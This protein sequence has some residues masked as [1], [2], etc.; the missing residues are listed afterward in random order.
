MLRSKNN[1][2]DILILKIIWLL[3]IGLLFKYI[4]KNKIRNGIVAFLYKQ[5]VTWLFGLLVVEKGLIKYPVRFFKKANKSSFSFE[6]FIY[7]AIC[8][9]FNLNYPEEKNKFIKLLYYIF[10]S[11]AITTFEVLAERYTN[12][13][14]YVKWKWYWS[15]IT[16]GITYYS[17]RLFY[18][19]FYKEE[20]KNKLKQS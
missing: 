8:A 3:T 5:I 9:I 6:Y 7:P 20:F 2:R 14:K 10:H 1:Q 16:I 18:R 13:I 4:P 15:F 19:W 11:G 17:S 12:T